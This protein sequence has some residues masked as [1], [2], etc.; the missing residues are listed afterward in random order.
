MMAWQSARLPFCSILYLGEARKYFPIQP[1]I[2]LFISLQFHSSTLTPIHTH[3]VPFIHPHPNTYPLSSIH[4][5]LPQYIPTQFHSS[6]F[7]PIH[8]SSSPFFSFDPG[9]ASFLFTHWHQHLASSSF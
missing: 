8:F 4:L 6:S 9:R 2:L 1:C 5:L 7:T 3:S